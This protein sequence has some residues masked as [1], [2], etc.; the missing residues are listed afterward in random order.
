MSLRALVTSGPTYEPIDPVRFIGNR[1]SGKQ[2][3][4]IATALAKAGV[5]VTLVTGPV[6]L[7]DPKGVN[8]IHV[9]TAREML[10]ACKENLPVDIAVF[11]AAVSDWRPRLEAKQKIKKTAEASP[12]IELVANPDI[13][14]TIGHMKKDRPKLVVG[15]AAETQN[16]LAFARQKRQRKKADWIVG[17]IVSAFRGFDTD[18]NSVLFITESATEEWSDL[19]KEKIAERLAQKIIEQFK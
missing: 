10:K 8:T 17:N 4:S 9:R 3:H 14:Q 11:A 5:Q 7:P 16:L 1:S 15:F 2:G 13:L 18:Y 19:P 12:T 6:S